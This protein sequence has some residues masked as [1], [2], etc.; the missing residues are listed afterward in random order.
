LRAAS[1]HGLRGEQGADALAL[2]EAHHDV[3]L[4]A[5]GDD[6]V[7]AAARGA[8]GGE[9]LGEH[10]ALGERAAGAAGQLFE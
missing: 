5:G 10:A 6:G 2:G 4:G 1:G 8:A 3:G 9:D 7:G